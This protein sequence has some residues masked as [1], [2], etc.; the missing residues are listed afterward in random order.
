VTPDIRRVA[1]I[2]EEAG[3]RIL[4]HYSGAPVETSLKGDGS[5]LTA[6]DTAAHY[7]ILEGLR[8][9]DPSIPVLSEE[10]AEIPYDERRSWARFWLVDPL[11]GTKEFLRRNGEFTVNIALVEA[12]RPVMG[13]V[14]AP[15]KG[16]TYAGEAGRGAWASATAGTPAAVRVA[17]DTGS[18]L[19]AIVSRSHR[20]E[21]TE[22]FLGRLGPF[23]ALSVGSS[24]KF[25]LLAEGKAHV[26]PRF[27]PS[28][29]WDT[30]AGECV[31]LAAGGYVRGLDNGPLRYN[32]PDLLNPF[33]VAASFDPG[34]ALRS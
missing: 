12:G 4:E 26:Y 9:L 29:E 7:S 30:A 5:P 1:H 34:K 33:F 25:C 31:V 18:G 22:G 2:A 8:K 23:E 16:R 11:D 6:A 27:W 20:D 15:A 19:K 17:P 28:M 14:H 3:E 13:V 32:K 21:K 10:S 24:L